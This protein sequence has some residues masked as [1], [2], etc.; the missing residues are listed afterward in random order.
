MLPSTADPSPFE[1]LS[2]CWQLLS[3]K[4]FSWRSQI[5]ESVVFWEGR[6]TPCDFYC[7][8]DLSATVKICKNYLIS[9]SPFPYPDSPYGVYSM[10]LLSEGYTSKHM[11]ISS[12]LTVTVLTCHSMQ[13]A[14]LSLVL[15]SH[16][17]VWLEV[18]GN[19]KDCLGLPI[20]LLFP[21]VISNSLELAMQGARLLY[22]SYY[23][24]RPPGKTVRLWGE[25]SLATNS[26][27]LWLS[28]Y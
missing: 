24:W 7:R 3:C 8:M 6:Q 28:F 17:H 27:S 10:G 1:K 23:K 2:S 16:I 20:V 5:R 14:L 19:N 18:P 4:T 22:F 21:S 15:R 26:N 12:D 11:V 25:I 13:P 9:T